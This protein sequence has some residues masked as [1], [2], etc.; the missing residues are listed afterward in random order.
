MPTY[1][2]GDMW[3]VYEDADLFLIT[4]NSAVTKEGVL[5]M[6]R[7]IALQA[8]QRFPG[9]SRALGQQILKTCGSLGTYGVLISSRWPEAKLGAFQVKTDPHQ[10][11]SL[12]LIQKST[13]ALCAW[14]KE[15][16][17]A[18]VHLNFPGIG[19]GGLLREEVLPIVEQLP[20]TVCIWEGGGSG[21]KFQV[22]GSGGGVSGSKFQVSSSEEEVPSPEVGAQS[23]TA[24]LPPGT[25]KTEHKVKW[26]PDHK[27]GAA[28]AQSAQAFFEACETSEDSMS[29]VDWEWHIFACAFYRGAR[30][31]YERITAETQPLMAQWDRGQKGVWVQG[32]AIFLPG[33]EDSST[34]CDQYRQMV[35]KAVVAVETGVYTDGIRLCLLQ[36]QRQA[37]WQRE[38]P[39]REAS[40]HE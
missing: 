9:L 33:V 17:Q 30:W 32:E 24:E 29:Q 18:S 14:C 4:T 3:S 1:R 10:S 27:D 37:A 16:P 28:L 22:S 15:H 23:S 6:G 2:K 40:S 5:V 20:E 13:T 19:Y 38:N 26:I 35:A 31:M 11:A 25:K 7:G 12:G 8:N 39:P 36:K 34:A 21:S